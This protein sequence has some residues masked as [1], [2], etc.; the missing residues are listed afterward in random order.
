M[1][2]VF[3]TLVLVSSILMSCGESESEIKA[4]EE[5][6]CRAEFTKMLYEDS[7]A[8]YYLTTA[9]S[10]F[11]GLE[12]DLKNFQEYVNNETTSCADRQKAFEEFK[13]KV[14]AKLAEPLSKMDIDM[15]MNDLK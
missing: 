1:K 14:S 11:W 13:A 15:K 7:S 5:T 6:K 4:K 10:P 12:N 8:K 9:E 2:N 3:F